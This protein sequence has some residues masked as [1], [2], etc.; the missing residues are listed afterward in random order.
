M[1]CGRPSRNVSRHGPMPVRYCAWSISGTSGWVKIAV[2]G[3]PSTI[4]VMPT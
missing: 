4:I 2:P 1:M 3:R